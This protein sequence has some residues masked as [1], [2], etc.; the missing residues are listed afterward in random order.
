MIVIN[1]RKG[2]REYFYRILDH[3]LSGIKARYQSCFGEQYECFSPDYN[4]LMSLLSEQ[5]AKFDISRKMYLYQLQIY[6]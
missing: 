5:T 1:F 6:Q 3:N 4:E 2:S